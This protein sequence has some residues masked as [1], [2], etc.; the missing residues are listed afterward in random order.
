MTIDLHN[1]K[2][3]IP[4]NERQYLTL[5]EGVICSVDG[6]SSLIVN[7][8]LKDISF[9]ISPSAPKYSQTLLNS[10]LKFHNM[11]QIQLDLSKSIRLTSSISF[12][13]SL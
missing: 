9:R 11:L 4:D 10:I 13:L 12:T 8:G 3:I 2:P 7:R 1:F 5:L 6:D